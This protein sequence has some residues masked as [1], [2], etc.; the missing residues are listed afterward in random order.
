MEGKTLYVIGNSVPR[1]AAFD[2]IELLGGMSTDREHQKEAC[3][4]H[5]G[6][7]SLCDNELVKII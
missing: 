3:P 6:T 7:V 2:M 1:Q 5:A 4:K